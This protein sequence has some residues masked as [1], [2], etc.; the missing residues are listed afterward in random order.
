MFPV[1][2]K[3]NTDNA[4]DQAVRELECSFQLKAGHNYQVTSYF[5]STISLSAPCLKVMA[6]QFWEWEMPFRHIL[7]VEHGYIVILIVPFY[8]I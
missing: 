7:L 4:L 2:F 8:I 6:V 1:V 3:K 5:I